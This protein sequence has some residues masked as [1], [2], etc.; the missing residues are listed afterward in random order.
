[1]VCEMLIDRE[2]NI[3]RSRFMEGV[4]RS[5]ARL[6]YDE[7]AA[8]LL[9]EDPAVREQY[10]E[11]V[12]H[13]EELYRLY[14]VLRRARERRGAIDFETEE[15]KIVFGETARSTASCRW[16]ATMPTS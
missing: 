5:H 6:T 13:L 3:Q 1:M 10:R 8:M 14:K 9:E 4:M 16:S 2:G 15:T 12:P 11:L 7:V